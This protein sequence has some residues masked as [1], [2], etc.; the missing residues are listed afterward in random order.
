MKRQRSNSAKQGAIETQRSQ[1]EMDSLDLA[2]LKELEID[3]RQSISDLAKKLD[4]SRNHMSKR[5][6]E[7][8]NSGATKVLA[9]SDPAL[10]GFQTY[11]MIGI[12]VS[13]K[14]VTA[15]AVKLKEFSCVHLVV[16]T[17]GRYDIIIYV[18]FRTSQDLSY[19]LREDIP[20]VPGIT[21]SEA[22]IILEMHKMSFA[23]LASVGIED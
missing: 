19:F 12:N 21:S 2:I 13:P 1:K 14:K 17:A 9:F 11:A 15:A 3:G 16:T 22:M 5:V 8:L 10:L 7:L 4:I 6:Q 23:Y 20:K 18:L